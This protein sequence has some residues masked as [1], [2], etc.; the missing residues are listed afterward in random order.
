[1]SE[2]NEQ[3][4]QALALGG[5]PDAIRKFYEDW[6]ESYDKDLLRD[7]GYVGPEV[8]AEALS[9]R[10][11][12]RAVILDAGCGTGLVGLELVQ[13]RFE[14]IIDGI[15]LTPAM[16]EQSRQKG[17]YRDLRIADMSSTLDDFG[18]DSYDGVVCAGV[19]TNGHVGPDGIDELVRV[20]R[21]GAP[22]VLTV[23][24]SAW[25]ADGFKDKIDELE[26]SGKTRTLEITHSPYHTKE[27]VSCQLVVLEA[28]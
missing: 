14:L 20:A 16:L 11:A 7:I 9:R 28:A 22:I 8:A 1:M 24:D 26:A 4:E 15:D 19:F 27:D 12:D 25:E 23:R 18:D 21:P 17:V 2:E 6:S 5:D 3:L 10:V 13:R